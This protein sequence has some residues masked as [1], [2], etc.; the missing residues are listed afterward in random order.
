MQGLYLS[1][2]MIMK[3]IRPHFRLNTN[4]YFD[5]LMP[6]VAHLLD[7][8]FLHSLVKSDSHKTALLVTF[9]ISCNST[10]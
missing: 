6:L 4:K 7:L 8:H 5:A 10:Y 2:S 1:D 9:A 3:V